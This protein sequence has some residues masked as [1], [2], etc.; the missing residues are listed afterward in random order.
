MRAAQ[1]VLVSTPLA[2]EFTLPNGGGYIGVREQI[3][4]LAEVLFRGDVR[5]LLAGA[6][7]D[8]GGKN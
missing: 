4:V 2:A 5:Y 6:T 8:N 1:A 3:V 7:E